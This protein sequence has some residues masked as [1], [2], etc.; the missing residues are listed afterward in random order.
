MTGEQIPKARIR[1]RRLFRLIWVVPVIAIGVA[2]YLIWQHMRS[3]GR[4]IA[5]T[6]PDV[7]G[8]R[9]GQTQI[10]Y[11]GVQIGEVIGIEL[12]EDRKQALVKAPLQQSAATLHN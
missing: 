1:R 5:I 7:S 6:F 3:I 4:E 12:A 9:V 2:A 11:R 8:L 10:N